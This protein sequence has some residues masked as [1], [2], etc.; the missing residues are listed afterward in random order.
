M[1]ADEFFLVL[2]KLY[3]ISFCLSVNVFAPTLILREKAKKHGR[4]QGEIASEPEPKRTKQLRRRRVF[5]GKKTSQNLEL[6][7]G[8]I[9]KR[10]LAVEDKEACPFASKRARI[11]Q[12]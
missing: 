4:Q 9:Q 8:I 3:G 6:S 7:S 2:G 1:F 5:T 10:K 11:C 12:D